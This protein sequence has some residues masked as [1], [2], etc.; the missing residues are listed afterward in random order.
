[1]YALILLAMLAAVETGVVANNDT[2]VVDVARRLMGPVGAAALL[3]GGLL[4]T[5]SSANASILASS[6]INFAMGRDKLITQKI[7]EVHPRFATPYRAIAITGAIILLAIFAGNI[8]QLATMGSVLH[9]IVYG[10]L[11]LALI[12]FRES[13]LE[14]YDPSFEAPFY[15]ATP[16]LGAVLSFALIAFIEPFVI[17]LAAIVVA[18]AVIW[19]LA[20]ARAS[21]E[22][23]GVLSQLVLEHSEVLP[24][25]AVSATMSVQPNESDYRVLVPLANP[26][27]EKSLISLA[28]AIAEP[29]DET[30]VA[31]NIVQIPDQTSLEAAREQGDHEVARHLLD[32]ARA[33]AETYDVDVETHVV[34]SHR[35]FEEVFDASKRYGVDLT[36]MGWGPDGH[37]AP[38]RAETTIDELA[39]SLPNDFLVF[40]D[41]RFDPSRIL[42]PTAGGP[43]SELAAATA[44]ALRSQFDSEVTLLHVADEGDRERGQAF[45]ESWAADHGL[46]DAELRV[47]TGD[48]ESRIAETAAEATLLLIGA[49]ERGMLSRLVRGS[50]VLDVLDEVE[51]SVIL[52][53][54]R[55]TRTIRERLF[56]G[57]ARSRPRAERGVSP[58]PTT[59]A[60][61]DDGDDGRSERE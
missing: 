31:V 5:A 12:V 35:A 9:L 22:Q 59:P 32:R 49:T 39:H 60:V 42:L 44:R 29:R 8:E 28:S 34:L 11:N 14:S 27:H 21:V 3:F 7:N 1:M 6:R 43:D 38:G 47:E 24:D 15:P 51:C 26:A 13:N 33:D 46:E 30:V 52:A 61:G 25:A 23:E 2:A 17:F 36:V 45:L 58:E 10:L 16:I 57:G 4:A 50:L 41:R 56:G 55:H 53:E 37:G 40:R 20:Y 48:V 19:Y 54:K 18:F